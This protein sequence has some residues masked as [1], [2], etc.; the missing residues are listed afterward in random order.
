ME[1]IEVVIRAAGDEL[2]KISFASGDRPAQ[3]EKSLCLIS[4]IVSG[5]TREEPRKRSSRAERATPPDA[6]SDAKSPLES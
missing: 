1:S 4:W 2:V 6:A 5:V 3:T